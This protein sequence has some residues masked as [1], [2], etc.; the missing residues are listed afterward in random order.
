MIH[1]IK[2]MHDEGKGTSIK[3]ISRSLGVSKNTVKKYLRMD[4]RALQEA[5]DSPERIKVLDNYRTYLKQLLVR[6]DQLKAPK[7]YRKLIAKVPELNISERSLR[8][9]LN[10]LRPLVAAAQPR[11]Y[12]PVIDDVA[13]V[14]CQIDPGE[15]RDVE[16]GGI[17]KT[18][19]FVVFVLSYSRLM[20]VSLSSRPI[21]TARFIQMH[22]EAFI[23]GSP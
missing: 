8:R 7:V 21:D 9:Y 15:L 3:Q 22:D 18:V 12:E 5:L 13:G 6:H 4:E 14:Q 10:H 17:R 19:Y 2:S 23:P 20:Y 11:Y 1:K 16:I